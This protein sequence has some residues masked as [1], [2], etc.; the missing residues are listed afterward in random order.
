MKRTILIKWFILCAIIISSSCKKEPEIKDCEKNNYG[1]LI[2]TNKFRESVDVDI[3][4][5]FKG[6]LNV[7]STQTYTLQAGSTYS[8]YAHETEYFLFPDDEW[9]F[10]INMTKCAEIRKSLTP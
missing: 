4:G 7:G 3:D 9:S 10:S 1:T 6:T 2:L 8:V 5:K